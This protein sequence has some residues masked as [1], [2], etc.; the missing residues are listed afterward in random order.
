[1][2]KH[3]ARELFFRIRTEYRRIPKPIYRNADLEDL[4][5][6]YDALIKVKD[7]LSE[8]VTFT[9]LINSISQTIS[10]VSPKST[11]SNLSERGINKVLMPVTKKGNR[12]VKFPVEW[13]DKWGQ[14]CSIN[15]GYWGA[16]NYAA[17]DVVGYM[18]LLKEGGD[19][20]PKESAPIF[21]DLDTIRIREEQ[22]S[23]GTN[24][25][26]NCQT[27]TSGSVQSL[28]S[29][30]K[31][32][33]RFSDSDF[34]K[35]TGF[36]LSSKDILNLLLE[37]ARVEFK[38]SFPVRLKNHKGKEKVHTMNVFSRLFELSETVNEVRKDGIVQSRIY[39]VIFNTI[40]GELFV[41][42]LMS[43][44]VSKIE[45]SFYRLPGSAQI[46]YRR[47]LIHNTYTQMDINLATIVEKVRLKDKNMTNLIA[48]VEFG[49]LEP[50]KEHG[51]IDSYDKQKGLIGIKY[52]IRRS[53]NNKQVPSSTT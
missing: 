5:A 45:N 42:N 6:K 24:T 2:D 30:P 34:R 51:L 28:I 13:V 9:R 53:F 8:D 23:K 26:E 36:K 25:P 43:R 19:K 39:E 46:F 48:T 37:T 22:L 31:Y 16:K 4:K 20:L 44:Y 14:R 35:F 21:H 3:E 41:N 32:Y 33:V 40:L 27:T 52:R 50:L 49:I 11:W 38:L 7:Y 12:D 10:R 29:H 47:F 18:F 17:M 1:M 15:Y